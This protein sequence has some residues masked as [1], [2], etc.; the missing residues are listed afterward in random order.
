MLRP[1]RSVPSLL[2]VERLLP[3]LRERRQRIAVVLDEFGGVAGIVTLQ[4]VAS[5]LFGDASDEFKPADARPE[6]LADG[7]MRLPGP[8]LLEDA[9]RLIGVSWRNPEV[10]TLAGHVLAHFGRIPEPGERARIDGTEIEVESV[11]NR[12]IASVLVSPAT[13]AKD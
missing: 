11:R 9:A 3:I 7:R 1:I 2:D 6:K 5:E 8:M 4:D 13:L 12:A 10:T